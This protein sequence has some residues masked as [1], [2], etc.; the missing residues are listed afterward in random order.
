M[1][2]DPEQHAQIAL[3]L[4]LLASCQT[5]TNSSREG[6][7]AA[8]AF[9]ES[10]AKFSGLNCK[11]V[12]GPVVDLAMAASNATG[13]NNHVSDVT[14]EI[15]RH[16]TVENAE[17]LAGALAQL[18]SSTSA[19]GFDVQWPE[20]STVRLV[21]FCKELAKGPKAGLQERYV[22]AALLL[23]AMAPTEVRCP[24]VQ[25]SELPAVCR[26][27]QS[28][29]VS[30]VCEAVAFVSLGELP[31]TVAVKPLGKGVSRKLRLQALKDGIQL[32][33]RKNGSEV[34]SR[35][36]QMQTNAELLEC[37][38]HAADRASL[39]SAEQDAVESALRDRTDSSREGNA[40][41]RLL[42][43]GVPLTKLEGVAASFCTNK[44]ATE[45][46]AAQ[47]AT[48]KAVRDSVTAALTRSGQQNAVDELEAV[49][50]CLEDPKP[51]QSGALR[52]AVWEQVLAHVLQHPGGPQNQFI[53]QLL[54][55]LPSHQGRDA[56]C[57][58]LGFLRV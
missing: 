18:A 44:E 24:R 30:Q 28:H 20:N 38:L 33:Q 56:R 11:A 52:Q 42:L 23:P 43:L 48:E 9:V 19:S 1:Q 31:S 29:L 25:S 26:F 10:S 55:S 12:I 7:A 47:C 51:G 53:V 45:T 14:A 3:C 40:L 5:L 8:A 41:R 54:A 4:R 49:I 22:R 50:K 2:L 16:A 58:L 57:D 15:S 17:E 32:L 36:Q 27:A 46:D 34:E 37:T 35:L 21:A 6:L 39:S 13:T